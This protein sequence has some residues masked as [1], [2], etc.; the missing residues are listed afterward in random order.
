MKYGLSQNILD[1]SLPGCSPFERLRMQAFSR[2]FTTADFPSPFLRPLTVLLSDLLTSR[3]SQLEKSLRPPC[4]PQPHILPGTCAQ[5]GLT[6][7]FRRLRRSE[8]T[9]SGRGQRGQE[10]REEDSEEPE[11]PED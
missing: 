4:T 9:I 7:R 10:I 3:T 1:S 5:A 2:R 8:R 6:W 11:A